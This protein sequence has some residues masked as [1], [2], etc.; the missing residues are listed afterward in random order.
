MGQQEE[1]ETKM[2]KTYIISPN[3]TT[4]TNDNNNSSSII[5]NT[6]NDDEA[7]L[8]W[9]HIKNKNILHGMYLGIEL[10]IYGFYPEII[11]YYKKVLL[12]NNNETK[13]EEETTTKNDSK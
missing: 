7:E 11:Q 12:L 6:E 1:C 10:M 3:N 4:A 13:K 9:D 5:T 8:R 2:L